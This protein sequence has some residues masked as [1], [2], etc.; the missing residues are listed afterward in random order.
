MINPLVSAL[1]VAESKAMMRRTPAE[2]G[3]TWEVWV[4]GE[5]RGD[6][7][8]KSFAQEDVADFQS[9]GHKEVRLVRKETGI[10]EEPS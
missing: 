2:A 6:H 7:V 3:V 10:T 5:L 9:R 4:D 1:F 8:Y